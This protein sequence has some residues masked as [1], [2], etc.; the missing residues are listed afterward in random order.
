VTETT[1]LAS[2]PASVGAMLLDQAA[3]S[4]SKEAFRYLEGER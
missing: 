2:R 3:A 4:P 1:L